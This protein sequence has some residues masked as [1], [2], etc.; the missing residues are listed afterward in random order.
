M[1]IFTKEKT[2]NIITIL[3]GYICIA[4]YLRYIIGVHISA[5]G[6][7]LGYAGG[8][9]FTSYA[10]AKNIAETG[11]SFFNS[12]LGA[13]FGTSFLDFMPY[14]LDN[15]GNLVTKFILCFT[16]DFILALNINYYC[17]PFASF[18][19]S[20]LTM[21]ELKIG[22]TCSLCGSLLFSLLPYY[23]MRNV[24]HFVLSEYYF[25]PLSILICIWCYE[26][27]ISITSRKNILSNKHNL[28]T[29]LFC[30]L[31]ANNGIGYYTAFTCMFILLS[32]IIKAIETK[33]IKS[34]LPSIILVCLSCSFF[35]MNFI[36][37][38]IHDYNFGR[39]KAIAHRQVWEA[40]IAGLKISQMLLPRDVPG[41]PKV[42]KRMLNYHNNA[43]LTNE[44]KTAYL[45]I[46]GSIGFLFMLY[47]MLFCS[48]TLYLDNRGKTILFL[49]K[50]NACAVLFATI[51]GFGT[52]FSVL[53]TPELR[54][55]NRI[56]VFIAF[57]VLSGLLL[58]VERTRLAGKKKS[59]LLLGVVLF[60][61]FSLR[62]QTN[63]NY[64]EYDKLRKV[65]ESDRKFIENIESSLPTASKVYQLPYHKY[66]EAGPVNKMFD[67]HE[68]TGFL[69]SKKLQW[70]YGSIRGRQAD[71]WAE[72]LAKLSLE[73]KIQC[74]AIVG[75]QGIYVDRRAYTNQEN[76]ELDYALQEL[77]MTKPLMSANKNLSFYSMQDYN[78]QFLEKFTDD[79]L[80]E[81]RKA[82]LSIGDGENHSG[83]Y[84][85]EKNANGYFRWI[86]NQAKIEFTNYGKTYTR[87]I[88]FE[89]FSTGRGRHN[90]RI[91]INDKVYQYSISEHGTVVNLQLDIRH[92]KNIIVF[93][94]DAPQ[95]SA[96]HETRKM[97]VRLQNID[98]DKIPW[99]FQ[100]I[101][102][103]MNK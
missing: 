68:L 39:N 38:A 49:A 21:K 98:F 48:N 50:L 7:P 32:G 10:N 74:L 41:L 53:V 82:M 93:T 95:V 64:P 22:K 51:G 87:N 11:W 46:M 26:E 17:I 85:L 84:G 18:T 56:S 3:V 75:F 94:T 54:S 29:I 13:P 58:E 62:M 89:A 55:V 34:I 1:K 25:V 63:I 23:F 91:K 59:F 86:N 70:S 100:D 24:A 96:P 30:L 77:L 8:D 16:T 12:R 28:L 6:L 44:N 40:D 69:F 78:K 15:F 52:I 102:S 31:I 90:L 20:Y 2:I 5:L 61:V 9:D 27:K 43:P 99:G 83:F 47:V 4:F 67:Y 97:Y 60:T 42:E 36:P 80:S 19:I 88:K 37:K 57:I 81:A 65:V 103:N 33:R 14:F 45:G 71:N 92:G 35:A 73:E 72:S 76:E 79:K 66:P 101:L